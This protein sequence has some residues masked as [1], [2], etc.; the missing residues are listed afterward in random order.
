MML[1]KRLLN[2]AKI[3]SKAI[4]LKILFDLLS[5]TTSIIFNIIIIKTICLLINTTNRIDI[6]YPSTIIAFTVFILLKFIFIFLSSKSSNKISNNIKSLL[7]KTI[8]QS[9]LKLENKYSEITTQ[10]ELATNTLNGIE[11]LDLYFSKFLPQLIYCFISSLIVFSTITYFNK[12]SGFILIISLPIIPLSI[13]MIS[14]AAK[15][16][17]KNFWKSYQQLGELFLDSLNG[18]LTLKLFNLDTKQKKLINEK[19]ESFRK[20][21]MKLLVIQLNS[22]TIMDSVSFIGSLL[23]IFAAF[24]QFNK[25][26]ISLDAAFIILILSSEFFIP[27]RIL[28]SLF[29]AA[30]NGVIASDKIFEIIDSKN[31]NVISNINNKKSLNKINSITFSN[32]YFSYSK[33]KIILNNLN[34]KIQS[35]TIT[36]IIGSSG[37]GKST[38]ASLLLN[39][40]KV[41]QGNIL[42]NNTS[43]NKIDKNYL[44][45]QVTIL[46]QNSNL[47]SGSI[48]ENLLI[49]KKDATQ[50]ELI[51]VLKKA[52]IYE[53][54][55]SLENGLD[56]NIGIRGQKLSGGQKQRIA[57]ARTLLYDS[58]IIIF[59]EATSNIDKESEN[60]ILHAIYKLKDEG[61][62]IIIISH[63]LDLIK[64]ADKIITI[65]KGQI[66]EIGNHESLLNNKDIY[67][68]LFLQQKKLI[69][70]KV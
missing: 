44:R 46:A 2:L 60:K 54:I 63:Q 23:A 57:L 42:Y 32:V 17:M 67:Y 1:N 47:F 38:I 3:S 11:A 41:N 5:L 49:A 61:K 18:L 28:G 70:E 25:G 6:R 39:F 8:L 36:A 66:K 21:T 58:Q 10:S 37:S 59:D 20:K 31:N 56:Y 15:K 22:I 45:K 53:F 65:E 9:L 24:H 68:N 35:K 27:F 69:G 64:K 16:K 40:N 33:N 62:T 19:S 30:M 14:K 12:T 13:I 26:V 48:K 29:H 55:N 52:D 51:D 7:R 50:K 43:I 34:F 4:K